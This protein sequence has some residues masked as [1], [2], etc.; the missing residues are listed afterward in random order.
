MGGTKTDR[1]DFH[2]KNSLFFPPKQAFAAFFSLNVRFLSQ[3][4]A[5]AV[6]LHQIK[7]ANV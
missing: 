7:T 1:P 3:A 6:P 5:G 4:G 2:P